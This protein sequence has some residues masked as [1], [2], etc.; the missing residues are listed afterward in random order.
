L[1]ERAFGDA[2]VHACAIAVVPAAGGNARPGAPFRAMA[3]AL[4]ATVAV[5]GAA[6][7]AVFVLGW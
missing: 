7:A 1:D 5:G 4:S 6:I 2:V 3:G